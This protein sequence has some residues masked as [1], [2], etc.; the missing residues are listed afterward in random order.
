MESKGQARIEQYLSFNLGEG[1]FAVEV[2]RTKEILDY[3]EPTK[4]PQTPD[5]M[6]GVINLR[7]AVVPVIDLRRKLGLPARDVS[8]AT[9]IVVLEIARDEEV[10][11]VGVVTDSVQE[12]LELGAEEIEP[13]PRIGS[14]LNI[15]YIRGMGK[16]GDNFIILLDANRIFS[17]DEI[18]LLQ[19]D[20]D[21]AVLCA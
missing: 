20:L 16:K 5:Y 10:L 6:L 18:V 9:C 19:G 2:R 7:G 1:L 21:P 13:P 11:T 14:G 12:V 4:V 17:S 15:D 8:Q 3:R